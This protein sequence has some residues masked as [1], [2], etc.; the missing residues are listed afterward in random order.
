MPPSPRN[1]SSTKCCI[2]AFHSTKSTEWARLLTYWCV[3]EAGMIRIHKC[4]STDALKHSMSK[5]L[6][7]AKFTLHVPKLHAPVQKAAKI[8][9]GHPLYDHPPAC[10]MHVSTH[11]SH[12]NLSHTSQVVEGAVPEEKLNGAPP[13][14]GGPAA[15]RGRGSGPPAPKSQVCSTL[16]TPTQALG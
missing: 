5:L 14:R 7:A 1:G 16:V 8:A 6:T 15:A 11:L 10:A 12:K 3:F 4:K 9:P 13:S 2:R